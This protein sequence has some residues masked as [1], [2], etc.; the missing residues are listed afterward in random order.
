V[1]RGTAIDVLKR[2]T[3]QAIQL[4]ILIKDARIMHHFHVTIEHLINQI[5]VSSQMS[6]LLIVK[7]SRLK[8][9]SVYATRI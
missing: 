4:D 2:S 9:D 5:C 3:E 1:V 8:K 6:S 7:I